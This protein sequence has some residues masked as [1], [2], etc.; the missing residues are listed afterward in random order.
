MS[1]KMKISLLD[2][3]VTIPIDVIKVVLLGLFSLWLF[4]IYININ[5][6]LITLAISYLIIG[7]V[8]LMSMKVKKKYVMILWG[9]PIAFCIVFVLLRFDY[10]VGRI[11]NSFLPM[12]EP[13]GGGWIGFQQQMILDTSHF[14]G[15]ADNMSQSI[16]MFDEGTNFAF[17]AILAHFGWLPCLLMVG[18]V[19]AMSIILIVDSMKIKDMYGKLLIVGIASLFI[20]QSVCNVLMNLNLGL[21]SD[22]SIP[23][24]SY[25]NT[26]LIV[27]MM[28]F[29]LALSV[30]RRKDIIF[31]MEKQII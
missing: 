13:R 2:K 9:M 3:E 19:I 1:K 27:N 18:T 7:T 17:I 23:F 6:S 5:S 26:G 16:Q 21:K 24:I 14:M 8:K 4:V 30:Y 29:S 25:G 20:L 28:C 31:Q 15:Q 12:K 22:F 10:F 11:E